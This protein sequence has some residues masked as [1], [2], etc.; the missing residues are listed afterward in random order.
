MVKILERGEYQA[1]SVRLPPPNPTVDS[2]TAFLTW[3]ADI[4][5]FSPAESRKPGQQ[6]CPEG[7]LDDYAVIHLPFILRERGYTS[8]L[9]YNLLMSL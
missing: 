5:Y 4:C 2:E 8:I 1:S 6:K 7:T 3:V 9:A